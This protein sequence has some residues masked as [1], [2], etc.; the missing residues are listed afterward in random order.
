MG[1]K[2]ISDPTNRKY[3]VIVVGAGHAG[4]EAALASAKMGCATL[5]I[6]MN[7]D[8]LGLMSSN[9]AIGG[10]GK[11]QLVKE[12]DA[13]GGVMAKV[14]DLTAIQFRQL[15]T[16]K[17][18]AVRSSRA[19]CDRQNYRFLLRSLCEQEPNLELR[20]GI[21]TNLLVKDRSIVG[22]RTELGEEF[23]SKTVILAPGTFLNGLIHIGLL[24][25]PAGRL[26]EAPSNHLAKNLV[27]LGF[28]LRRFKTG[29]PPRLDGRT[30]D[31][32]RLE[33]Q[34][35]DEPPIPF[36]FWT[37]KRV[38]NYLPCYITYTNPKTH[39]IIKSGLDRSPL[40]TGK[41]KGT[42]V[43]YCP[44]IEDKV[45]KFPD[46]DRHQIFIEPEGLR[47]VE[48]YP[49]GISTS[50]PLDIQ[51][52]MLRSIE[53]LE[54]V[55]I[56]RP[57]YAVEHDFSCPTQLKPSLETRLIDGL[58]FAGQ[59]NGTTGYEEAAAQGLIAGINAALKVKDKEPFILSRSDGYIGVLIDDLVTKGTNEPY[60][61][62][63]SRVEYRLVLREDNA[64]LRLAPKGY[65][66]GLLSESCYKKVQ[67]KEKILRQVLD[68]LANTRIRPSQRLNQKL[69]SFKSAPLKNSITLEELL[70]RP[71]IDGQKLIECLKHT[72]GESQSALWQIEADSAKVRLLE[73][74]EVEVKYKGYIE[75]QKQQIEKFAELESIKIPADLDFN[76]V[77]GLSNEVKEKL[78]K[79]RPL[80]LGQAE[81]IPGVTPA[82]IFALMVFLKRL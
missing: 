9:P 26:N 79:F 6:T 40:Y 14:T 42:G 45:V 25:F 49:N 30:I 74:I 20:Q 31:F 27:E 57:G 51:I 63:T 39:N 37:R 69:A 43:R 68:W 56:F 28:E 5:L 52:K 46:R 77:A 76:Q 19:Q 72:S 36:S 58:F 35:G 75:Q 55:E 41:I 8:T 1:K 47:T 61:M 78:N 70:R 73:A 54:K 21:V 60:R 38:K 81:R 66:L 80:S 3:D 16:K 13:L 2:L 33:P 53:G 18:Q 32:S 29:T 65:A 50:L 17:G 71:E 24:S 34:Y 44:S 64:D 11:G 82:A 67:K 15:N 62:F 12:I 48:F 23:K 10:I 4:I 7:L 22:V 59:I